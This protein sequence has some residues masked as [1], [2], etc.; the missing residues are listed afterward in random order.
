[1]A[2]CSPCFLF[3]LTISSVPSLNLNYLK[4][5]DVKTGAIDIDLNDYSLDSPDSVSTVR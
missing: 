1:M 3:I 5:D 4:D 2:K